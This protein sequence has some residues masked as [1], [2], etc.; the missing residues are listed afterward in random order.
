MA[1]HVKLLAM[2]IWESEFKSSPA[3]HKLDMVTQSYNPGK[4][5]I[6]DRGGTGGWMRMAGCQSNSRFSVIP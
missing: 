3:M 4:S 6:G 2:K 1:S 5:G